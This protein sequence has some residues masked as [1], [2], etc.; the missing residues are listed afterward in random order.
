MMVLNGEERL[1]CE[2]DV[3]G[4]WSEQMLELQ[5]LWYVL[6]ESGTDVT[7]CCGKVVRGYAGRQPQ[8][9]VGY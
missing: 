7:R 6:D 8:K 3:D 4:M 5:Y 1:D 9:S 2:I